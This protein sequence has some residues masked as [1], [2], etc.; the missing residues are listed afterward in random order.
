MKSLRKYLP[1]LKEFEKKNKQKKNAVV[2]NTIKS[3]KNK[4]KIKSSQE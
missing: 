1:E 2:M 4:K 3:E